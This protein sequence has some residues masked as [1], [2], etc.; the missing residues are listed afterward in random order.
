MS[1]REQQRALVVM[2]L[3]SGEM[4]VPEAARLLGL[5]ERSIRRL[6]ARMERD[7]PAGLVHGTRG[8]TSPRRLDEGTYQPTRLPMSVQR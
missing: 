1:K 5:S 7:G 4:G 3:M 8:R 6:R 2:R